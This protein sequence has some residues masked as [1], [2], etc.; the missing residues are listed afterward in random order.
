METSAIKRF[1]V[2]EG[3]I[4]GGRYQITVRRGGAVVDQ[5]TRNTMESA[6]RAFSSAGYQLVAWTEGKRIVLQDE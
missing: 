1:E 2:E 6:R 5:F 3:S 4:S